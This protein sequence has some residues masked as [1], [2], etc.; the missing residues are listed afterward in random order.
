MVSVP[1]CRQRPGLLDGPG[2]VPADHGGVVVAGDG[3]ADH[4]GGAV[5]AE[6]RERIGQRLALS[7][8]LHGGIGVVQR[9]GPVAVHVEL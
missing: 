3:D 9:V 1:V 4:L 5:E 7:T 8:R 2:G 6:H